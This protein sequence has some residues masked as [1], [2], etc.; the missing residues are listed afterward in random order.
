MYVRTHKEEPPTVTYNQLSHNRLN[1]RHLIV[2]S[3]QQK[4][5]KLN[6]LRHLHLHLEKYFA[7]SKKR[8]QRIKCIRLL[9]TYI[10]C[11][12]MKSDIQ[13]RLLLT[14]VPIQIVWTNSTPA[15]IYHTCMHVR[16]YVA[17]SHDIQ[18]PKTE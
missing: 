3:Q 2:I 4:R 6:Q 9:L 11:H 18:Y 10:I 13:Y 7:T 16:A 15:A 5:H 12:S 14:H 1:S 8:N 17:R